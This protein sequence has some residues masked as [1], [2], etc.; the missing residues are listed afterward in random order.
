[1][2]YR[3]PR[4]VAFS[5]GSWRGHRARAGRVRFEYLE[6]WRNTFVRAGSNSEKNERKRGA[7]NHAARPRCDRTRRKLRFSTYNT[8]RR[9]WPMDRPSGFLRR[10]RR[11]FRDRREAGRVLAKELAPYRGKAGLLVLGLARGGVPVGW[12]V[13]AALGAELDV[14]L[15][16]KL[17]V[18]QWSEL[19]MGALAS[20]GGVVMNDKVVSSLHI[21]DEQVRTVGEREAAELIRPEHAYRGE[22]PVA[23]PRGRTVIVV[24]DGIATG[25]SI[26]AA[27]R[28]L[29]AA[30]PDSIVV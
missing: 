12:E 26:L 16:R 3:R 2:R 30:G 28:A 13:A 9:A 24:D 17:G 29:R 6:C 19:A 8:Q 5:L 25:A 27:V 10:P 4:A 11:T 1:M 7:T 21:S 22:R 15:V 20:G 23:D 18:P 14:F